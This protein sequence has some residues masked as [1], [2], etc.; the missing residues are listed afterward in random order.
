MTSHLND[1]QLAARDQFARQSHRYAKGHL[2]ENVEDVAEAV[3]GMS[4]PEPAEVLDVATGA[5]HT[6]LYFAGL[7]H[8]VTLTDIAQPMLDR[9]CELA[10][11]RRLAVRTN[12][13]TA[14]DLPYPDATFDLVTCRVA[15]HHFSSPEAFVR[16]SAR[17]LKPGGYLLVIDG[18]VDD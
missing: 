5:G 6:G 14:E 3:K 9:A 16:E 15:A 18:S 13:H 12:R 2:L 4:L 7:G 10:A 17:V 11:S 8:S 1:T